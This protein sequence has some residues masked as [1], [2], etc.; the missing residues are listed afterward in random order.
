MRKCVSF[1]VLAYDVKSEFV[2]THSSFSSEYLQSPSEVPIQIVEESVSLYMKVTL[3]D[4]RDFVA[5][6]N[7]SDVIVPSWPVMMRM[8]P[9]V[10]PQS[11]MSSPM[12]STLL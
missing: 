2:I 3:S 6:E 8:Q 4:G 7:V 11:H 12:N 1:P 9:L 5:S 10:L